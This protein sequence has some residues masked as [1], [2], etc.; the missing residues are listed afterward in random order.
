MYVNIFAEMARK[1]INK[2]GLAK[3]M[4]ISPKLLKAKLNKKN[5][6]TVKDIFKMQKIFNQEYCTFE[7][8]LSE[9]I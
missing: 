2:T 7:Y 9:K 8:L 4:S 6:L 3:L 1:Q 5:N